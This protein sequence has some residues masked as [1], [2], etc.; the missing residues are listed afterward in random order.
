LRG[1]MRKIWYYNTLG[2]SYQMMNE[3][4]WRLYD[5]NEVSWP[6]FIAEGTIC[7]RIRVPL[8]IFEKETALFEDES[9]GPGGAY[10]P[11]GFED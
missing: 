1:I 8:T 5:S 9:Y 11:K 10:T 6:Y 4:D 7:W 2:E 3:S